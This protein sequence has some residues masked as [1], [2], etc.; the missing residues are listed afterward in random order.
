VTDPGHA[1]EKEEH[2]VFT[3]TLTVKTRKWTIKI[4][5]RV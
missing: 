2:M 3:L 5:F 1:G 4:N